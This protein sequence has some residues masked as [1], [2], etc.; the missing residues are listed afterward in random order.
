MTSTCNAYT[1]TKEGKGRDGKEGAEREGM[2][3]TDVKAV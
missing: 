2:E 1:A 3:G